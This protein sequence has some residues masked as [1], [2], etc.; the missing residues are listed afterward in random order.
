MINSD[1]SD[2]KGY[3]G[4][5]NY[6]IDAENQLINCIKAGDSE[7]GKKILEEIFENNFARGPLSNNLL[8]MS[9]L[10]GVFFP[11]ML[12]PE[13]ILAFDSEEGGRET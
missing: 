5:Y 2:I 13:I 11:F 8:P 1:Y 4:K 9:N 3:G 10:T 7:N 12:N 6:T